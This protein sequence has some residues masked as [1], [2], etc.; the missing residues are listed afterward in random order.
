MP[1]TFHHHPDNRIII[2]NN[3]LRYHDTL[4]NLR[5]D[6][7]IDYPNLPVGIIELRYTTGETPICVNQSYSQSLASIDVAIIEQL[8]GDLPNLLNNQSIRLPIEISTATDLEM[9]FLGCMAQDIFEVNFE[10]V[11]VEDGKTSIYLLSGSPENQDKANAI[12]NNY[13]RLIVNSD[14]TVMT[15]GDTDPVIS[16][17][18]VLIAGDSD[19]GYVALLDGIEYASGTTTVTAGEAT[20]NLVSP[21][22][23][24][25]EIFL[26]RRTGNYASG[27][28]T[29]IVSEV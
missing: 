11:Y 3:D 12:F 8:I 4:D 22:D 2:M 24:E 9:N 18:D 1:T 14:K 28:V 26:Y 6:T 20:L 16:C 23:G 21:V 15:E 10:A 17:N 13:D 19:V 29:I 5:I 25:Y 27:S 7:A